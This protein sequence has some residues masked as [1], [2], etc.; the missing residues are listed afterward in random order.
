[1]ENGTRRL[2]QS[3]NDGVQSYWSISGLDDYK[4]IVHLYNEYNWALKEEEAN[5]TQ[6]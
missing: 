5:G 3:V 4:T 1:M 6:Q 2:F